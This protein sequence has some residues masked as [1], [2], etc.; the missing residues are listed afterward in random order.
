MSQSVAEM[1]VVYREVSVRVRPTLTS[2]VFSD[3]ERS[4]RDARRHWM[5]CIRWSIE[6]ETYDDESKLS[7]AL[8]RLLDQLDRE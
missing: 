6:T 7:I 5:E 8:D 4:D 3:V 2:P 1:P